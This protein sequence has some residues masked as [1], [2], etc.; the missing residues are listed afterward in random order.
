M[1]KLKKEQFPD[2]AESPRTLKKKLMDKH[3]QKYANQSNDKILSYYERKTDHELKNG[4]LKEIISQ[5]DSNA[6]NDDFNSSIKKENSIDN[7]SPSKNNEREISKRMNSIKPD[8]MRKNDSIRT[9]SQYRKTSDDHNN[10]ELLNENKKL[11]KKTLLQKNRKD[12][13]ETYQPNID[14]VNLSINDW[15]GDIQ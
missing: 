3:P 4:S 9:A 2:I 5:S 13:Q 12:S 7:I 11:D 15:N 14:H 8:S 10:I 1:K 6:N